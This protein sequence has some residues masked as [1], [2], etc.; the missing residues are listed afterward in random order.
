VRSPKLFWDYLFVRL[1][2]KPRVFEWVEGEL[3]QVP[4]EDKPKL[5][6]VLASL[7][8]DEAYCASCATRLTE[9]KV[10]LA[11]FSDNSVLG[12]CSECAEKEILELLIEAFSI[13][14]SLEAFSDI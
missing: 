14:F 3:V 1:L 13:P 9:E 7:L 2:N 6:A 4:Q 12:W 10:A 8:E 11:F 5:L